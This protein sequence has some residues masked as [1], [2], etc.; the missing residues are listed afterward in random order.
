MPTPAQNA[1]ITWGSFTLSE[2]T[3]YA[4]DATV[5]Y[6]RNV[7][8]CGT[9]TVRALANPIPAAYYGYYGLLTIAH[10]GVIKFK[11]ACI[12]ERITIE[13]TRNDV[14]RHAFV[15]RIYYPLRNY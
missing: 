12:C 2:V 7:G 3:E 6:G 4:V 14:L 8:D 9:V 13:A 5:A 11:G 10:A 15:F 1:T